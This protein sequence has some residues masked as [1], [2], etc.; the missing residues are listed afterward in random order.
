MTPLWYQDF[1]DMKAYIDSYGKGKGTIVAYA[2]G[3][4]LDDQLTFDDLTE[5][6]NLD[7]GTF[8]MLLDL[9][10]HKTSWNWFEEY[11]AGGN[12]IFPAF[13]DGPY[14]EWAPNRWFNTKR[15]ELELQ[16]PNPVPPTPQP[17]YT[18]AR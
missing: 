15:K 8:S 1:P 18:N 14:L 3:I 5:Q 2:F 17:K 6:A 10:C 11:L 7:Q 4:A 16:T 12:E 9:N 13:I